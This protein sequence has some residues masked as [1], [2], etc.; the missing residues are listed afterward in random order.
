M[1]VV[2]SSGLDCSQKQVKKRVLIQP[3]IMKNKVKI[4]PTTPNFYLL[5]PHQLPQ[6]SLHKQ[7]ITSVLFL[8]L[9]PPMSSQISL[10][11]LPPPDHLDRCETGQGLHNRTRSSWENSVS[12]GSKRGS[13]GWY[14]QHIQP[15]CPGSTQNRRGH[16]ERSKQLLSPVCEVAPGLKKRTAFSSPVCLC[17]L[18]MGWFWH[19]AHELRKTGHF[20]YQFSSTV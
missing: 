8:T 1:K 5:F 7:W 16:Q 4:K 2:L 11:P 6:T 17:H 9:H 18:S 15:Q 12:E 19:M 3:I 14:C 13:Q 10:F 20:T